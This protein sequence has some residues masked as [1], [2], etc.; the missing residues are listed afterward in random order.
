MRDAVHLAGDELVD[1]FVAG[2]GVAERRVAGAVG[3]DAQL[4]LR[5]VGGQQQP[6]RLAG[7]ERRADFAAFAGADGD[8][9][10]VRVA[11]AEPAR[12]GDD[13]VERG[14]DAARAR[15]DQ[16]RQRV[17][18]RAQQLGVLAV[19]DD[20][21]R[22]RMQRRPAPPARS[23]SVLAPVLVFLSTGSFSSLNSSSASCLGESMLS[24]WPASS[25]ISSRSFCRRP[26]YSA[27]SSPS[28]ST[29]TRTPTYSRSASTSMSGVSTF[30]VE[31][32]PG[33]RPRAAAARIG[34]SRSGTSA[35]SAA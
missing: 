5:V 10:Q 9:L 3:E 22:Q 18:V 24:G 17:D 6:A 13:L 35:S 21:R 26:P 14:V 8:V 28:R 29:S 27:L 25:S 16:L 34:S 11:G 7:G 1:V 33:R 30:G 23:A 15:V 4:D 12:G 2:E 19:L 20:L 31:L 32:A